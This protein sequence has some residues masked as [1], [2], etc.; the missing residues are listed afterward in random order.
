MSK[1]KIMSNLI[2]YLLIS[3]T[4]L[5]LR[6]R[7]NHWCFVPFWRQPSSLFVSGFSSFS[8]GGTWSRLAVLCRC[9]ALTW[10]GH[11]RLVPLAR[12]SEHGLIQCSHGHHRLQGALLRAHDLLLHPPERGGGDQPLRGGGAH[13]PAGL[14]QGQAGCGPGARRHRAV[15][16]AGTIVYMS[17]N[18]LTAK[19]CNI[20]KYFFI[21]AYYSYP[22][23]TCFFS[24]CLQQDLLKL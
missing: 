13:P 7:N 11:V 2:S 10:P 17:N 9:G 3:L 18:Y 1:L 14:A 21:G 15:L 19:F 22:Y 6:S 8:G 24:A 23:D 5:E 12:A 4:L 20:C 16:L